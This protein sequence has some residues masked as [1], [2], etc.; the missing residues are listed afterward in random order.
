[1]DNDPVVL[2]APAVPAVIQKPPR[3]EKSRFVEGYSGNPSGRPKGSKNRITLLRQSLELRLREAAAP[4]IL[5]VM[6]KAIELAKSGDRA[7]IKLLLELHMS[8]QSAEQDQGVERVEINITSSGGAQTVKPVQQIN[9]IEAEV[10]DS[11]GTSDP[12]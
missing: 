10:V 5:D 2:E 1:M 6:T 7:M 9:V 11:H 4:E 8:K 12:A 3:D